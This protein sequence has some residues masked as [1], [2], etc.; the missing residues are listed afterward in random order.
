MGLLLG[1]PWLAVPS[2]NSL[3]ISEALNGT[4]EWQILLGLKEHRLKQET[5]VLEV[6]DKS[7]PFSRL[8]SQYP[9]FVLEG[10]SYNL[11]VSTIS[12]DITTVKLNVSIVS[13]DIVKTFDQKVTLNNGITIENSKNSANV[14]IDKPEVITSWSSW[15][16]CSISCVNSDDNIKGKN[17]I[18]LILTSKLFQRFYFS[19]EA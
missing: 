7:F 18:I 8:S 10:L 19:I 14:Y 11:T 16:P 5:M 12:E 1:S 15:G 6:L 2:G 3:L 13:L 9:S 17:K 4:L